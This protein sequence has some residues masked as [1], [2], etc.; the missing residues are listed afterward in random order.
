MGWNVL[1]L[2][3]FLLQ[4]VHLMVLIISYLLDFAFFHFAPDL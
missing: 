4:Y 3:V 2:I 1:I